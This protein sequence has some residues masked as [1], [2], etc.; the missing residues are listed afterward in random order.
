MLTDLVQKIDIINV[1]EPIGVI[2]YRKILAAK[3]LS[4]LRRQPLNTTRHRFSIAKIALLLFTVW[5]ANHAGC[6][7]HKQQWCMPMVD[8]MPA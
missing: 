7:S 5:V 2:N 3:Y 6:T 1:S 8:E 4:K